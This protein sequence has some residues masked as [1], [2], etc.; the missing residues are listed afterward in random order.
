MRAISSTSDRIDRLRAR[1]TKSKSFAAYA[2][3]DRMVLRGYYDRLQ[4]LEHRLLFAGDLRHSNF[5]APKLRFVPLW[6]P[7]GW[8]RTRH[9]TIGI[10]V[11]TANGIGRKGW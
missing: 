10:R 3:C 1:P 9:A 2:I 6:A 11:G 5:E 4:R 8:C 7:V